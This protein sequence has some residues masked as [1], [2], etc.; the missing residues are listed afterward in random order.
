MSKSNVEKEDMK[1]QI[2]SVKEEVLKAKKEAQ[3]EIVKVYELICIYFVG[4]AQTQWDKVVAEI[5]TKD[6]WVPVNGESHKGP[7]MKTWASFLDCIE[8]HKLTIFSCDTTEV[9]CY[10]M[11]Q[12]IKKPQ[13]VPVRSFMAQMV[14][15]TTWRIYLLSRTVRW[16]L[17]TRRRIMCHS[18]RLI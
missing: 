10:Y 14:L 4:K 12:G 16:L 13:R 11:Q 8:L 17:K 5:H 3:G 18:T 7:H 6:H 2:K 9:Q 1:K 15:M